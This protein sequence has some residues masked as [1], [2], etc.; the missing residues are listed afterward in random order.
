MEDPIA[1]TETSSIGGDDKW[2]YFS[3]LLVLFIAML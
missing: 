1:I 3:I 2:F